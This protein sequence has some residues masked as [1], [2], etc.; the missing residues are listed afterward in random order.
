MPKQAAMD[1]IARNEARIVE[2]SDAVWRFAEIGLQEFESSALLAGELE[3]G[4]FEVERG[5]AGMPTAFVASWGRGSPVLGIMGEYDA[6]PGLSQAAV[7][8]QEPAE[9][10][11]AGHACGHNIHGTSGLAAAL[12][13]RHAMEK[14]G[15]AGTVR[16]FGCPAEE[17]LVGKVFMVRDGAFRG[18]DAALSHHPGS[19]NLARLR[20]SNAMNSVKFHFHGKAAH[21]AASPT[22]GRGAIDAVELMNVGV[23]FMREHVVQEA[24]I[25][26]VTEDGGHEPNVIPPYARSWYYVR[27]PERDQV[28]Q[29]YR[30]ILDIARGADLMAQTT[31]EVEFLTGCMN[32]LPN[33]RLAELVTETM[34]SVGA[35]EYSEEELAWAAEL[36]RSIPIQQKREWL[37]RSN[38]PD[39]ESLEHVLLDR[40][41]PEPWDEGERGGGSTDVGDVS[42]NLPTMEFST[43][44]C[45]VGTP[46]HS[47]QF[48]AQSGMSIGHKSLLFAARTMACSLVDLLTRSD[49]LAA[50]RQEFRDRTRGREYRSPL[51]AD[52]RPPFP[53][54]GSSGPIT[55]GPISPPGAPAS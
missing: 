19:T 55:S 1:W 31:H 24:R 15:L 54:G 21:A 50:V 20:S 6:L 14:T 51:P 35:P 11:A 43:A 36:S 17:T 39:G 40:S 33:R 25:H 22:D 12:A 34:R 23:N 13:I 32:T 47:W 49:L 18:V 45:V 9:E 52:L 27:A 10:G 37:R 29:I 28:E 2:I 42:W 44:T 48:A 26:Y 38:R 16:F 8:H 7:P 30:W 4:G 3:R 41:I 5:V 46:G 53:G